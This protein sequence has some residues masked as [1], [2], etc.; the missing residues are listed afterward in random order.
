MMD[1]SPEAF[2]TISEVATWLQTPAHVLRFWESRFPEIAPV[3]RAGGRRYYRPEDM[4]L[5]GGIK[6]LLHDEGESIKAVQ[7]RLKSDGIDAIAALAP[8]LDLGPAEPTEPAPAEVQAQDMLD[9]RPPEPEVPPGDAE[10]PE[11]PEP[12]EEDAEVAADATADPAPEPPESTEEP[13]TEDPVE[14]VPEPQMAEP[15]AV[16]LAAAGPEAEPAMTAQ[17]DPPALDEAPETQVEPVMAATAPISTPIEEPPEQ[18]PP[19]ASR[20]ADLGNRAGRHGIFF[21][22]GAMGGSGE[23]PPHLSLE[24]E[25]R[26]ASHS[27]DMDEDVDGASAEPVAS[28]AETSPPADIEPAATTEAPA[29]TTAAAMDAMPAPD[30]E[31]ADGDLLAPPVSFPAE[32]RG[33]DADAL[34]GQEDLRG[35]YERL[36]ALRNR[37][38]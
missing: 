3:K 11:T 25:D 9:L 4:R 10:P 33:A 18:E 24:G 22:D 20:P 36:V 32:L 37:L 6:R 28:M 26:P 13:A 27:P 2:R 35:L 7:D 31:D 16:D 12:V 19:A 34:S 30:P 38:A 17:A 1:K 21:D 15:A 29:E 23:G 8:E 5:L 14:P